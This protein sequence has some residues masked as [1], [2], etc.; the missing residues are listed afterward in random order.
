MKNHKDILFHRYFAYIGIGSTILV[1]LL[2][3]FLGIKKDFL[4]IPTTVLVLFC[5][6][7]VVLNSI[8]YSRLNRIYNEYLNQKTKIEKK[9]KEIEELHMNTDSHKEE[10][11]PKNH[12]I[13]EEINNRLLEDF[14]ILPKFIETISVDLSHANKTAE[15]KVIRII[16]ALSAIRM[17][18]KSLL[19]IMEEQEKKTGDLA[20]KQLL[21]LEE[22]TKTLRIV[23]AYQEKRL[24][25]IEDDSKRI[26]E[27]L[28]EI[29]NL[30]ALTKLIREITEQT[31]LLALNA[32]VVAARAGSTG[33]SFAVIARE[34]RKLSQQ[35]ED[36][37]TQI[38]IQISSIVK[39]I[40]RNL[41][42]IVE[43]S[44]T[45]EEKSHIELI[46][47]TLSS[48]NQ[49]F[50][51]VSGYFANLFTESHKVMKQVYHDIIEALGNVQFQDVLR[52]KIEYAIKGLNTMADYFLTIEDTLQRRNMQDIK[53]LP[54]PSLKEKVEEL[55]S[56]H[57]VANYHPQGI[58]RNTVMEKSP[59]IELF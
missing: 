55:S 28:H 57:P 39:H 41:S 35:I 59:N 54:W 15:E 44:R 16:D 51:E 11:K 56:K 42:A 31:N 58:V 20:E 6:T 4:N 7:I 26:N 17:Q 50:T 23:S 33:R 19:T 37:T 29:K 43:I 1:S 36:T 45:E 5:M 47:N 25:Q 2:C 52:Q 21:R 38:E 48:M 32:G 53:H 34:I 12:I 18:T 49:A 40:E 22:N 24:N 30:T 13:L 3:L 8:F 27:A 46:M 9:E 14:P 10:Q